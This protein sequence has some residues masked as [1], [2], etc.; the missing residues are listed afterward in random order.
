M[1]KTKRIFQTIALFFCLLLITSCSNLTGESA[2]NG[3]GNNQFNTEV[4]GEISSTYVANSV[5]Q[6]I[7]NESKTIQLYLDKLKKEEAAKEQL[8]ED[9]A[10]FRGDLLRLKK[11]LNEI[12][13]KAETTDIKETEE[14]S[15][16]LNLI[17]DE[18]MQVKELIDEKLD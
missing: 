5:K 15:N 2:N 11:S 4:K 16:Q 18:V 17:E 9:L 13:I 6:R 1:W 14:L 10:E 3:V 12:K 8:E 7:A